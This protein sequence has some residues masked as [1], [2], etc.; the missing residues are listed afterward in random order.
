M[1]NPKQFGTSYGVLNIAMVPITTIYT[2]VGLFGYIKYGEKTSGS[3]TLNL[4]AND[5]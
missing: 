3:I 5:K 4:P 2:V 1:A